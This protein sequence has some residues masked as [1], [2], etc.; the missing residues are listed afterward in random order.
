MILTGEKKVLGREKTCPSTTL[1]TKI[2]TWMGLVL[3]LGP[4]TEKLVTDYC[5]NLRAAAF[6]NR[7]QNRK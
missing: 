6:M 1:S 2:P 7:V 3:N 4:L 5:W